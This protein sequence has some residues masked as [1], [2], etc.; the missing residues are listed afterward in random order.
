MKTSSG[1]KKVAMG[2][3]HFL[4]TGEGNCLQIIDLQHPVYVAAIEPDTAFW[5]LIEKDHLCDA[6]GTARSSRT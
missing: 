6:L 4:N 3:G 5:C 1:S 2:D